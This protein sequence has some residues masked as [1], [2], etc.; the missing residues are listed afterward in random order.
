MTNEQA[1]QLHSGD[2]VKVKKDNTIVRVFD[3]Y[4]KY[5]NILIETDYNGYTVFHPDEID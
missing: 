1:L 5:G 4:E 3:A 2:E